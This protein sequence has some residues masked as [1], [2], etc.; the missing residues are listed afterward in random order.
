MKTAAYTNYVLSR[1]QEAEDAVGGRLPGISCPNPESTY[2]EISIISVQ[3][4]VAL[5]QKTLNQT[6][7]LAIEGVLDIFKDGA[8]EKIA[9]NPSNTKAALAELKGAWSITLEPLSELNESSSKDAADFRTGQFVTGVLNRINA[10]AENQGV[11]VE[12]NVIWCTGDDEE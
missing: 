1:Q 4:G 12:I 3:E 2:E 10:S 11:P 7:A 9:S 5:H 6:L 8:A